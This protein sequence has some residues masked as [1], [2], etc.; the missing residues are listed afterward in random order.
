VTLATVSIAACSE[1]VGGGQSSTTAGS[2]GS[3]GDIK[4]G[5]VLDITGAGASLGVPERQTIEMLADQVNAAGGV[6][7]RKVKLFIE[8]NQSTE[9]GAAKATSKLLNTEKVD[10]ILGASRTGPSLA[11]RRWPRRPRS[12]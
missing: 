3:T 2:A 4:I 8:D 7:G 6:N 11:M 9:D 10:V 12:R 5:V 1:Q